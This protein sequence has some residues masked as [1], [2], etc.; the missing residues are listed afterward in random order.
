MLRLNQCTLSTLQDSNDIYSEKMTDL[1][2]TLLVR[3]LN[4][5]I[6]QLVVTLY[7]NVQNDLPLSYVCIVSL[8]Q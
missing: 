6:I 5:T 3:I 7:I 8:I 2:Y 1:F 4:T